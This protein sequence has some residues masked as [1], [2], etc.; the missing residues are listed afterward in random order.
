[1]NCVKC[2]FYFFI[3]FLQL[4]VAQT[5]VDYHMK[6]FGYKKPNVNFV[7]GYIEALAEAGLEEKSYDIIM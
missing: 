2:D 4:E 3:F 1:M 6:R 5:Y 7:C